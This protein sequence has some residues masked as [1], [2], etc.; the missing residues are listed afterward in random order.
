MELSNFLGVLEVK[1]YEKY[2]RLLA[3]VGRNK[4]VSL[5]YVKERVWNKLQGWKEQLL[6]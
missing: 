5:N 1:E 6:S 3:V 4:S 2:L